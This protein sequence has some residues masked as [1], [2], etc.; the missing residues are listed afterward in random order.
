MPYYCLECGGDLTYDPV[1]RQYTCRSCGLT[2]T[3]PQLLEARDRFN[4]PEE[5]VRKR[6]QKEYLRWWLSKK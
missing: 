6:R 1:L 4:E 5:D 2:F 3:L